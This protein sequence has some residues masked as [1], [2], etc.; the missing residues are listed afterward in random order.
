MLERWLNTQTI[1]AFAVAAF[2]GWSAQVWAIS[3][4]KADTDNRLVDVEKVVSELRISSSED[5]DK[6]LTIDERSR[7]LVDSARRIEAMQ[8]RETERDA[9][10]KP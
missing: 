2:L 7:L 3:T 4:W 8:L 1:L 10:A 5:H 6:I 9:I